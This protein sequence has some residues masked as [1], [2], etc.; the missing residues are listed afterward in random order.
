M[1][2][3]ES[4][5]LETA[6]NSVLVIEAFDNMVEVPANQTTV[7]DLGEIL[8]SEAKYIR[9]SEFTVNSPEFR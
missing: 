4:G 1:S 8:G 6:A 7:L 9:I 5:D 3:S 2:E